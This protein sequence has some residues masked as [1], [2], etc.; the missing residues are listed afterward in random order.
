M[1]LVDII[2]S[3]ANV[4][5]EDGA[6]DRSTKLSDLNYDELSFVELAIDVELKYSIVVSDACT[7][8]WATIQDVFDT[9]GES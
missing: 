6:L 3:N 9:V 7:K 4:Q 5:F 8:T 1:D 2:K